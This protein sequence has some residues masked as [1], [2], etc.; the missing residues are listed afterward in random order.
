[1][2]PNP[3]IAYEEKVIKSRV[4]TVAFDFPASASSEIP[5]VLNH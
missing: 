4:S 1:L 2:G 5:A 3:G